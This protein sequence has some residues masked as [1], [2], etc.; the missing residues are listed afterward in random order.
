MSNTSY[1]D[2]LKELISEKILKKN[3]SLYK[4]LLM[5]DR[6]DFVPRGMSKYAYEDRPLP[7]G[8]DQTISQPYTIAF[9]LKLLDVKKEN[10]VLEIGYGSGWQTMILSELVGPKGKVV[11]TEV[12]KSIYNFGKKNIEKYSPKNVDL[13]L[14][15]PNVESFKHSDQFDRIIVCAAA[16]DVPDILIKS[17]NSGGILVIPVVNSILKITRINEWD[18][19]IEEHPGFAFVPLK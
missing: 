7:I 14:V 15:K 19:T 4:A 8:E 12:R 13:V 3:S 10:S 16:E 17:L 5:F 18:I 2:L 11:A 9:M 6:K 1:Q